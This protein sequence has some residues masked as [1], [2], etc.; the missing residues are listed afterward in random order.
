[1]LVVLSVL[2]LV[3]V[4]RI[5]CGIHGVY[6]LS[7]VLHARFLSEFASVFNSC[8]FLGHELLISELGFR[9][10]TS[11]QTLEVLRLGLVL[12]LIVVR[13][14]LVQTFMLV[15]S[16]VVD[17]LA[18][19]VVL[20]LRMNSNVVIGLLRSISGHE[21]L[22]IFLGDRLIMTCS[23]L[24][25]LL[26]PSSIR[27]VNNLRIVSRML[28]WHLV[29]TWLMYVHLHLSQL[30]YK[31][32]AWVLSWVLILSWLSI[33]ILVLLLEL[34]KMSQTVG[35]QVDQGAFGMSLLVLILKH[36]VWGCV[37]RLG[38]NMRLILSLIRLVFF[39]LVRKD[40]ISLILVRV[41]LALM[42][43]SGGL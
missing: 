34:V 4:V 5:S 31:W 28:D 30:L 19:S 36:G 14:M 9:L 23:S 32:F 26:H 3:Q 25:V 24:L 10:R 15:K 33:V 13:L 41:V 20:R 18:L 43:I 37:W 16:W 6:R 27:I 8:L 7:F 40:W 42:E 12:S 17:V 35:G 22:V 29:H 21:I 38:R 2:E 39:L 1:M 11:L